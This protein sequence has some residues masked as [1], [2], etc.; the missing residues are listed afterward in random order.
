VIAKSV[1]KATKVDLFIGSGLSTKVVGKL[2]TIDTN[3]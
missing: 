3:F 1:G 2:K